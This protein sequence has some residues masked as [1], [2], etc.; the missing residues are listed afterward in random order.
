MRFCLLARLHTFW[1]VMFWYEK[2]EM[3]GVL[4]VSDRSINVNYKH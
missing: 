1:L 2:D 4:Y 3:E